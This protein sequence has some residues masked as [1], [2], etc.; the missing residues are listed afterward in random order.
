MR[1]LDERLKALREAAKQGRDPTAADETLFL[2]LETAERL[3][4]KRV[5][6]IGAAEGLTCCRLR[7]RSP[8]SA[9]P[10]GRQG[11]ENILSCSAWS[12]A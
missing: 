6:E 10:N 5:L 4:A 8:S 7:R 3:G 1:E 12:I 9:T 2:I 11:R